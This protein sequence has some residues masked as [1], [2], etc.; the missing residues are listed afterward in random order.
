MLAV[1]CG[2]SWS[3]PS[4][5]MERVGARSALLVVLLCDPSSVEC[6]EVVDWVLMS[7]DLAALPPVSAGRS[8]VG[9]LRGACLPRGLPD[10]VAWESPG[11]AC[12]WSACGYR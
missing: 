11:D 12:C 2:N 1:A 4:P 6:V 7:I 10:A 9:R 5:R 8:P 3:L